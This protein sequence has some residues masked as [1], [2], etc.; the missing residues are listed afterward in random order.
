MTLAPPTCTCAGPLADLFGDG[1]HCAVHGM[2]ETREALERAEA[3]VERLRE[4]IRGLLPGWGDESAS[5]SDGAYEIYE[6]ACR[7]VGVNP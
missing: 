2:R 3:N 1:K 7:I 6:E 5:C 4:I